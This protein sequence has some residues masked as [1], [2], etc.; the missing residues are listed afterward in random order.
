MICKQKIARKYAIQQE[1]KRSYDFVTQLNL[2]NDDLPVLQNSL[3]IS[4]A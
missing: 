4:E 2:T 1:L 3:Y